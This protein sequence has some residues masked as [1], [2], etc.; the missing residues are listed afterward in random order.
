MSHLPPLITDLALIL[1]SA[2]IIT[3]IFRWLKQPLVLG[4]LI[5]GLLAGP[6]F[7]LLPTVIDVENI[8]IWA[9]IGVVF[10]L[11]SLGL[12]FSFKK[13]MHVGGTAAITAVTE[14][15]SMLL[16]GFGIGIVLGWSLVNSILLGGML[17][18]SSTTIIIK[19]FDDLG[20]KKQKF[21][22]IVFGVLMV[23]DLVAILMMVMI[24][25]LATGNGFEGDIILGS[26]LKVIFFLIL[27]F[28][29]GI[30]LL[31][32]FLRKVEKLM[33]DETLLVISL[34]LCLGMV[35][36]STKTGFSAA[37]GAFV[38]GSILAGTIEAE[39]I[40]YIITPVKNLFGAIF[41][42][43]V[44]MMVNPSILVEYAIPVALITL[45]AIFG[46][47]FFS[48]LG[49][50]L[51]GQ[52][53]NISVQSGFS[54]AQIGEFA[55]IIAALGVSLKV[56]DAYIYPIVVAVSVITTFTTP[57][58]IRLSGPFATWLYRILSAPAIAF[59]DRSGNHRIGN[60]ENKQKQ[61][62]KQS[63]VQT[64]LLSVVLSSVILL[65]FRVIEPAM[66]DII[67]GIWGK[68]L[69]AIGALLLMSPFL[70]AL[71]LSKDNST[72]LF[73]DLWY[74][75][76][77]TKL[78]LVLPALFRI[79]LAVLFVF[80][81]VHRLLPLPIYGSVAI[82]IVIVAPIFL[83]RKLF[84]QYVR[85]ERRFIA[86][87]NVREEA[88]RKKSPFQSSF[89]AT[90]KNKDINL[91]TVI[92][93]ADTPYA[94]KTLSEAA[95]NQNFAINV[96]KIRRGNIQI[97]IPGNNEYLYPQDE[98]LVVGTNEQLLLFVAETSATQYVATNLE[99]EI[100]LKS[101]KI[102]PDSHF[103]DENIRETDIVQA[104]CLLLAIE[105]NGV[106]MINPDSTTSFQEGDL[107][108]IVGEADNIEKL[109]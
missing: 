60:I 34:G 11:F 49:V 95:F 66:S 35:V 57:Y 104:K 19:A 39:H 21:T 109:L 24:S 85:I 22:G 99:K 10:L 103:I 30:F 93:P 37:L 56:L 17:S 31:P 84:H 12:E 72:Q 61:Y 43:S 8:N 67:P 50:L 36:L 27:W 82:A 48:T 7:Q 105:R 5:A 108:W 13:L 15:I 47:A 33:N 38:M 59:L 92:L 25:A 101:L 83:S 100:K 3:L 87:F 86:N 9:E 40:E 51:S 81:V 23:E 63:V 52:P 96:I 45:A 106:V 80:I 77:Y 4:Y 26:V 98:L 107:V 79:V 6:Y 58:M 29:I 91:N 32:V 73:V 102:K 28:L 68:L 74:D 46:K 90:F 97:N 76:C 71:V 55:F 75:K 16:V 53:L 94:G 62:L 88:Q 1:I 42:V 44:G 78:Q 41:F 70:R 18:M 54:L 69:N 14:I 64:I 89:N 2:G 20:L 65:A